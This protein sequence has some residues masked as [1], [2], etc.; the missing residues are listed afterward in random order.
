VAHAVHDAHA[1]LQAFRAMHGFGRAISAPQCNHHLRIVA[2]DLKG[3]AGNIPVDMDD[4]DGTATT[5]TLFNPEIVAESTGDTISLWDDCMSF[6]GLMVRVRRH[7]TI[8]VEF[9]AVVGARVKRVQWENLPVHLSELVQ[10]EL[11]HLDGVLAVDR[12]EDYEQDIVTREEWLARREEMR[13][14][15]D[16]EIV[17]TV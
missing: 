13:A 2:M 14:L 9:D 5:F 6:P 3:D 15:V 17:P 4:G 1:K 12:A 11:D 16:Y 7:R 8:S 10:H